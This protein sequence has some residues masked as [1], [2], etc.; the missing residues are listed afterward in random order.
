MGEGGRGRLTGVD[1]LASPYVPS[2]I[3]AIR[4]PELPLL[5]LWEKV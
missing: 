4:T 2:P 3:S 1:F 5:P